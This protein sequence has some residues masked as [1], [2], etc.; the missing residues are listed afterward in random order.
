[1][2]ISPDNEKIQ[3]YLDELS[4]EYE[5]LLFKALI[6]SSKS[7]DDISISELLRLD[8]EIKKPLIENYQKQQKRRKKFFLYGLIYMFLGIII[9]LSYYT[10]ESDIFH[11]TDGIVLLI[12]IILSA[13][14][15]FVSAFSFVIP[16]PKLDT[17]KYRSTSQTETTKLL[18]FEVIAKWRELEGI[19]SDLAEYSSIPTPRSI[20]E[21]LSSSNF[22]DKDEYIM[23]KD[24]LKMRN[25]IVHSSDIYMSSDEIKLAINNIDQIITRLKRIL[26]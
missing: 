18:S 12:S 17:V 19:V 7:I 25:N 9:L 22:I 3:R 13:V 6:E 21:Y 26:Y 14:G 5:D 15:L 2:S 4:S 11:G 24:F 23:L 10:V 16:M 20:I 8:N 1:M